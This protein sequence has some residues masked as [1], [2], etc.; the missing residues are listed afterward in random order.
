MFACINI[1]ISFLRLYLS[2]EMTV[3]YVK[4]SLAIIFWNERS[5]Q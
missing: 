2:I 1:Q 3:S 5:Q 4:V